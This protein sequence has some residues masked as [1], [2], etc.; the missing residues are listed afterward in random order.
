MI[1]NSNLLVDNNLMCWHP[2]WLMLNQTISMAHHLPGSIV[3]ITGAFI[4]NNCWDEWKLYFESRGYHCI[5]PAWP[6]KDAAPEEL[7]NRHP[8]AA[9]ASN[10]LAG[11]ADHFAAVIK[12]LPG[13]P[14][15]IGHSLGGLLVQ[16]LLDRGLGAAGVAIHS[17]PPRGVCNFKFSYLKAVWEAMAFFTPAHK[18]YLVRFKK[19]KYAFANGMSCE[20]Q[21]ELYYRY[22]IPESKAVIRDALKCTVR[23]NFEKAHAP[24]LF[25]SGGDDQIIPAALNYNNYK[26]YKTANSITAYK[27]FKGSNHLVFGHP[28]WIIDAG[29]I[30]YWLQQ[31][32]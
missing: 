3:F 22:A 20:L 9:I 29:F 11:L 27:E 5:A 30:N 18:T 21:K 25:I 2:V 19:W 23:I 6:H 15:L 24:L 7:R 13:Q 4:G 8:D 10:R 12:T 31:I 14:I 16:L 17:F 26:K 1:E 28:A 32:K